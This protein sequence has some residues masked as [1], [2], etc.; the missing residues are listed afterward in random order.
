MAKFKFDGI[1]KYV[2]ALEKIGGK[3]TES[4]LKYAVYPGAAVVA[5][6]V[7]AALESHRDSGELARSI[8]LA[9]MRN[10]NGYVNTKITFAGYDSEKPSKRFPQGVPNAVKAASL[11]SGN[12]R[13]Q[14]GT[15]IISRTTK[16]VTER[17]INEMSKAL[18]E[19]IGQIMEG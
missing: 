15:H 7:R 17:A 10:D 4:V 18:D 5:D 1:D 14:V 13:G 3:N 12:S 9:D 19:K 6:A 2:D 11:E 16:S 8:S